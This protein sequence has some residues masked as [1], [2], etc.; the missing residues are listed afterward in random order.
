MIPELAR[1]LFRL[2]EMALGGQDPSGYGDCYDPYSGSMPHTS[3]WMYF[4][5][6]EYSWWEGIC[7][8]TGI[9]MLDFGIA[10]WS[11]THPAGRLTRIF[12]GSQVFGAL[13]SCRYWY[14]TYYN[15]QPPPVP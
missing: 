11:F 6:H 9:T 13:E 5:G 2:Q 4:T 3:Y 14:N 15:P 7:V 8:N 10:T 1:N 12:W